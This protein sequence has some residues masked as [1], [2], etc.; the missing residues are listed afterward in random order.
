MLRSNYFAVK[1]LPSFRRFCRRWDLELIND[2]RDLYGFLCNESEYFQ[3]HEE[4]GEYVLGWNG[5]GEDEEEDGEDEDG[6]DEDDGPIEP[7]P[8][9][10][11]DEQLAALLASDNVAV[12][13]E[14]DHDHM[15]YLVGRA[16]AVNSKH[17]KKEL[18]LDHIYELAEGLGQNV[19]R[20]EY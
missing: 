7:H 16:W 1:D 18:S 19:T 11:F 10:S 5:A 14:V 6:E 2:D 15:R 8:K 9:A 3:S 20:A 4:R 12:V 17:E 13:I